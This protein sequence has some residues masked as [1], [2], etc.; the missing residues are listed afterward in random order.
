MPRSGERYSEI[1]IEFTAQPN[2]LVVVRQL[3][4]CMAE[5]GGFSANDAMQLEL[6]VD[7]AC[8]NSIRAILEKEGPS[9][10]TKVRVE[11][12]LQTTRLCI[13]VHD[14]GNDFTHHFQKAVAI[15]DNCDMTKRRGYGLQIIKTFMDEV[16]YVHEPEV[17]NRL[18][19]TKY[20]P[21]D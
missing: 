6:C 16:H 4:N 7:E 19:L 8:S 5:H 3:V 14:S 11:F 17:G 13:S 15:S 12:K 10:V 2:M 9:P 20:L 1:A 18:H 21:T